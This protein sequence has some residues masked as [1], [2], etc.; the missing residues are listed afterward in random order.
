MGRERAL[1]RREEELKDMEQEAQ[2]L[3]ESLAKRKEEVS[4][5]GGGGDKPRQESKATEGNVRP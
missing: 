3:Q 4:T 5:D 2:E 1:G